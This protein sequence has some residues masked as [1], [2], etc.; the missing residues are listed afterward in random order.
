MGSK[1]ARNERTVTNLQFEDS[2]FNQ[3]N[4]DAGFAVRSLGA[5]PATE[6]EVGKRMPVRITNG[7]GGTIYVAIGDIGMAAP[8]GMTN[9]IAIL[10]KESLVINTGPD[11]RFIRFDGAQAAAQYIIYD[12]DT[13]GES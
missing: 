1:R 3:R 13:D 9:G 11:H 4:M 5:V 8:T 6:I 12:S 7:S 2:T 10:D